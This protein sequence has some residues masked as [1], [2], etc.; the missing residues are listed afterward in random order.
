MW[1]HKVLSRMARWV[2][3][4]RPHILLACHQIRS[5][6]LPVLSAALILVAER[7]AIAD[8]GI[9]SYYLSKTTKLEICT[10]SSLAPNT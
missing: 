1:D 10:L 8:D 5:E 3:P 9:P 7:T 4:F 6:A 2:D